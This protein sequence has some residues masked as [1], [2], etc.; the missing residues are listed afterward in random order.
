M[1]YTY[2]SMYIHIYIHGYIRFNVSVVKGPNKI[3]AFRGYVHYLHWHCSAKAREKLKR[4]CAGRTSREDIV[5]APKGLHRADPSLAAGVLLELHMHD[6]AFGDAQQ[7]A[8][9]PLRDL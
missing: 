9:G 1:A 2:I 5:K 4:A 6:A 3:R 7:R 8:I